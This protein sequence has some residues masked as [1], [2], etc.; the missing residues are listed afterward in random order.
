MRWYRPLYLSKNTADQI[1]KI[2]EKAAAG[3]WVP[4]IYF[5]TL[6]SEPGHLL[7]LFHNTMLKESIFRDVQR[8]DIVGVAQGRMEAL[9]MVEKI[10]KDKY[11]ETGGFDVTA[12]FPEEYFTDSEGADAAYHHIYIE[13]YR[14]SA[15]CDPGTDPL[16]GKFRVVCTDHLQSQ[17]RT[18]GW[19]DP[20]TS[21]C[22][23]DVSVA[24]SAL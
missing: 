2:R 11:Q 18:Q 10:V 8:L 9:R 21:S 20:G 1:D 16:A 12:W 4:G 15:S 22:R 7:D 17:G 5:V 23:L 24:F 13:N 6:S 19:S 14:N 3:A